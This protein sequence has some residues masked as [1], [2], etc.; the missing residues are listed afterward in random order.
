MKTC[1]FNTHSDNVAAWCS[2]H[3]CYMTVKQ[4]RHKECLKKQC[5]YLKRNEDHEYWR[6]RELTKQRRKARK[7]QLNMY[8]TNGDAHEM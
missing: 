3:H 4:M 8:T 1:L 2:H 5:N 7:E 6:Q